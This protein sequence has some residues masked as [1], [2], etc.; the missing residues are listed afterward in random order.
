VVLHMG[1]HAEAATREEVCLL[2]KHNVI[3]KRAPSCSLLSGPDMIRLLRAFGREDVASQLQVALDKHRAEHG[4]SYTEPA[5]RFA[6]QSPSPLLG[7]S[8]SSSVSSSASPS[9]MS[10]SSSRKRRVFSASRSASPASGSARGRRWTDISPLANDSSA[11]LHGASDDDDLVDEQPAE[12]PKRKR[13][14][15][16]TT[17]AYRA[18]SSNNTAGL[19]VLM[20]AI[21]AD[22]SGELYPSI[23]TPPAAVPSDDKIPPVS[24]S[25]LPA[26]AVPVVLSP[27]TA[28]LAS[29]MPARSLLVSPVDSLHPSPT[30]SLTP[31]KPL[32]RSQ[33]A[34][35][36]GSGMLLHSSGPEFTSA[37]LAS[38]P[39]A[40]FCSFP[41]F[42]GLSPLD[43]FSP[44]LAQVTAA[45][46][47]PAPSALAFEHARL[48]PLNYPPLRFLLGSHSAV[49]SEWGLAPAQ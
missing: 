28:T 27:P 15:S 23:R 35:P 33:D 4:W 22:A 32:N 3:G 7:S 6:S 43:V 36:R 8:S 10:R 24:L 1:L 38:A 30:S 39:P 41:S 16:R 20:Q 14:S 42:I 45:R 26:A 13:L 31:S 37:A 18:G 25:T 17:R 46:A 9:S 40:H 19:D 44:E 11:S 47:A 5:R 2:K 48:P 12:V 34:S 49:L 21:Q 29:S